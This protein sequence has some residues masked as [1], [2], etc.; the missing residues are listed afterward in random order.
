MTTAVAFVFPGQ[1]CQRL[2]M[3][4]DFVE[5]FAESARVFEEA[6][7]AS[8]LDLAAICFADETRLAL[9]EFQQPAILTVEIAMCEALRSHFGVHPTLFGG[10]SLGE[11]AALVAAGALALGDAV[12]L[13]RLRG[14]LMQEAVAPGEG[15]MTAILQRD[16][17]VEALAELVAPMNVDIANHNAPD[18]AVISG[19]A[20]DVAR[21]V[22]AVRQHPSW[23]A[24]T[25]A[26]RVSAPFHSR[27]MQP[28]AEPL[29]E[30]LAELPLTNASKATSVLSNTS[31]GFHTGSRPALEDALTRQVTATVQWVAN[32]RALLGRDA[33]ILEVGPGR[34]L[35]GFFA[36]V[37]TTIASVNSVS[38]AEETASQVHGADHS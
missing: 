37:G 31:G 33:R 21:A 1:G 27:Y 38:A 23:K 4:R 24:R 35:R 3:G 14:R 10:H 9:T 13:V 8:G 5:A 7:D 20:G 2:G 12:R 25:I 36:S 18:Q 17:D 11:Y 22:E 16:L 26:L 30:A 19:T 15:A 28:V 32:M 34:P 29:A 6:S